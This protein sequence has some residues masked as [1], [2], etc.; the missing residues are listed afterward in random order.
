MYVDSGKEG[1]GHGLNGGLGL[2]APENIPWSLAVEAPLPEEVK[3]IQGYSGHTMAVTVTNRVLCFGRETP[4]DLRC[5]ENGG[6]PTVYVDCG[7]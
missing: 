2:K 3:E 4:T 1:E 7:Y 6:D 5:G